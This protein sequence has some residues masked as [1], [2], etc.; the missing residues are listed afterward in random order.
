MQSVPSIFF[1][2]HHA[3]AEDHI[4]LLY[5]FVPFVESRICWV[6]DQSRDLVP[7]REVCRK[8]RSGCSCGVFHV[9][10]RQGAGASELS[11]KAE[12]HGISFVCPFV[13]LPAMSSAFSEN[14]RWSNLKQI[15]RSPTAHILTSYT[16]LARLTVLVTKSNSG[17][18]NCLLS[19]LL[20]LFIWSNE[21]FNMRIVCVRVRAARACELARVYVCCNA[22]E[23]LNS[24]ELQKR[25][26][27]ENGK[28]VSYTS[29]MV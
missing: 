19:K 16:S 7:P 2:F 28:T 17:L 13:D 1:M 29:A 3:F 24:L 27:I 11:V 9:H 12:H 22:V 10:S 4:R 18:E 15:S 6:C 20:N 23:S 21:L 8:R 14:N 25:L 5:S 26:E